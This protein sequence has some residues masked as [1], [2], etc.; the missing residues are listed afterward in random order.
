[1]RGEGAA[2][3][4][5]RRE[6]EIAELVAEGLTDG[7]IAG[8]LFIS[9]RTVE[10]HVQHIRNKLGFD[11]RAQIASWISRRRVLEVPRSS[12]VRAPNT[13]PVLLTTFVG[14]ERDLVAIRQLLRRSRLVTITG[15][16]GCGKTRLAIQAT[17]EAV[18]SYPAGVLF[19]GLGSVSD[20]DTVPRMVA[21]ALAMIE[22]E[23]DVPVAADVAARRL[24]QPVIVV[25]DNCEHLLES[26]AAVT[27]VLLRA[28][29]YVTFLC[30]S[31]QPL[32]VSAEAVCKIGPLSLPRELASPSVDVLMRSEAVRLFL[33][34]VSL[35]EP[36][37]A[38]D[39]TTT[40]DVAHL[41]RRL[42]GV[43]L[44]LELAAGRVGL[45][46][47]RQIVDHLG[48]R[49]QS[50]Q[51]R[52]APD[53]HQSVTA[54]MDWSYDLLGGV[55]Q[56]VFR[57][58]SVF[59]GSF[60]LEAAQALC[61]D[62]VAEDGPGILD[63]LTVLVEKSLAY[64][65]PPGLERYRCLELVRRYAWD[66]LHESGELDAMLERHH[67]HYFRLA[68]E[69][70]PGLRG[71]AQ[72]ESLSRL[73]E[74]HDNLR[75]ALEAGRGRDVEHRLRF[76]LALQ[77]FWRVRGHVSEGRAW[78]EQALAESSPAP[79]RVRAQALSVAA[80]LAWQQGDLARS[81]TWLEQC[82]AA[83]R[84]LDDWAGIQYS[85][86]NLG[87]ILWHQG[88]V[89]A[90]RACY[91]DSLSLARQQ[92]NERET[93]VVRC[94]LGVL[95]AY[96]GDAE[97]GEQHLQEALRIMRA[98]GDVAA[99]ATVLADLGV[100]ALGR[101]RDDHAHDH[102]VESLRIQS[103]LGARE[104]LAVCAEGM[105]T[106]AARRGQHDLALLLAGAA[107]GTR[108]AIGP[109]A[110]PWSARVLEPWLSRERAAAGDAGEYLRE[111]G[112]ALTAAEVIALALGE[113]GR[114]VGP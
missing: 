25:L 81:R 93:A 78:V 75:A 56:Q 41:C 12:A 97:L 79:T 32:R 38:L 89:A 103:Y 106:L 66:R 65:V 92:D 9:R 40:S 57:R 88:D 52:D 84:A 114:K 27:D 69:V 62:L 63:L 48:S 80:G 51:Q 18:Q 72:A 37:F 10:G 31:R 55:E 50:L 60:T 61:H 23:G 36:A 64:L 71:S 112:R 95:L 58:L 53:R 85:L 77:R 111:E 109:A 6:R 105:A 90:A 4:L 20:A 15:P 39:E 22:Q 87:L 102:F 28:S 76:V 26:C 96:Q 108:Q 45:M 82:L 74:D 7:A 54:A 30:T 98:L 16:G 110:D 19:V 67:D 99:V 24:R 47:L 86:G 29:P 2:M 33:D 44:A 43:P 73:A 113:G 14:R 34:R 8:R 46:P 1:M 5:S 3:P 91:E 17:S 100:A 70:A 42:E 94:N 68:E 11:N 21:A 107:E 101:D 83:W 59:R 13:L 104:S 49:I 35:R